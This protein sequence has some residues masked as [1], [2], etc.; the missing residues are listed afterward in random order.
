[1]KYKSL[2][3]LSSL[4]AI[5]LLFSMIPMAHASST[6]ASDYFA[7][8]DVW[9]TPLGGGRVAV[10]FDINATDIMQ[11]L[12]AE[13]IY[14][15]EQQSDG[16]YENVKTPAAQVLGAVML[17]VLTQPVMVLGWLPLE[18]LPTIPAQ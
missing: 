16:S 7:Y 10:E 12:G 6:R 5:A 1:M 9:A 11:E 3:L 17:P 4:F 18:M 15:W 13:K 8:T 14:I 2:R